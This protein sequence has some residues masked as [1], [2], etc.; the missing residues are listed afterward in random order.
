MQSVLENV[1]T[2]TRA[3][4]KFLTMI[5]PLFTHIGRTNKN[6][7]TLLKQKVWD[8]KDRRQINKSNYLLSHFISSLN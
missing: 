3:Q 6:S 1:P 4:L 5:T 2:L 8:E 7:L